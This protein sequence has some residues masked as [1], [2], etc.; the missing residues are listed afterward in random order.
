MEIPDFIEF[1]DEIEIAFYE[2]VLVA[3]YQNGTFLETI[4]NTEQFIVRENEEVRV[5]LNFDV[6]SRP[7]TSDDPCIEDLDYSKDKCILQKLHE[8]QLLFPHYL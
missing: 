8:V 4:T 7:S 5:T 6:L 1:L 3:F 2:D